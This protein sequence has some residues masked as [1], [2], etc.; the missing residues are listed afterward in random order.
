MF[1]CNACGTE[2]SE[3]K[4]LIET[5]GLTS[6]PFEKISVCPFCASSNFRE[7]VFSHCRCCGARLRENEM[8]YCSDAC[9]EKGEALRRKELK[10]L[11]ERYNSPINEILR[12]RDEY[13][14][15]HNTRY[16]YGQFVAI[17]MPKEEKRKC[18]KKRNT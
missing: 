12:K 7:T 16:S 4:I 13:N 3:A 9:K 6:P 11:K 5:H 8:G 15:S 1:I 14:L 18:K 2:F 17:I 10:R